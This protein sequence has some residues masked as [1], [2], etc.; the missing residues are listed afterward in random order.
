MNLR[1]C[2]PSLSAMNLWDRPHAHATGTP[3]ND[4]VVEPGEA[5]LVLG[6]PNRFDAATAVA[7]HLEPCC[8][9]VGQY[10]L[11]AGA[12]A[13]VYGEQFSGVKN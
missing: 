13:L 9:L 3:G 10:G 1:S 12:V 5:P 4:L 8:T 11:A 6:N 2:M 7:R